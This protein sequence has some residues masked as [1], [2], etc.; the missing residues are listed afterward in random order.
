MLV[1]YTNV[2]A[3]LSLPKEI[4]NV[5]TVHPHSKMRYLKQPFNFAS[6]YNVINSEC[7]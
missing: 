4:Q 1:Y 3:H 2:S 6:N 5:I 7:L